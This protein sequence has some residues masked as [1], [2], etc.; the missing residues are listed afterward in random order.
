VLLIVAPNEHKVR[1]EVGYG[2]EGV[3]TDAIS[4]VI[5]QQEIVPSFRT[6]NYFDGIEKGATAIIKVIH[7]EYQAKAKPRHQASLLQVVVIVILMLLVAFI[8]NLPGIGRGRG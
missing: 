4:S 3:L 6:G 8:S 1:I 2:L 7:G 5:I